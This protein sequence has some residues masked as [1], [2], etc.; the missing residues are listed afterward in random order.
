MPILLNHPIYFANHSGRWN[1]KGVAFLDLEKDGEA[2][3]KMYLITQEQ[4]NDIQVQEGKNWYNKMIQVG[5]DNGI[6]IKTL[7]H[8]PRYS[9]DVFPDLAYLEVIQRGLE[10]AYPRI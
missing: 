1:H 4:I 8:T 9:E 3:G 7:T 6:P 5:E 2:Y 10:E